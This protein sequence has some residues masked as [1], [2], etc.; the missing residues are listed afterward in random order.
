MWKWLHRDRKSGRVRQPALN[1]VDQQGT[2]RR[3]ARRIAHPKR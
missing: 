3:A 2:I 1:G